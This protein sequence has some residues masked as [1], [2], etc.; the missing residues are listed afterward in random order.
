MTGC[1][2]EDPLGDIANDGFE[3][4]AD[5]TVA[6]GSPGGI[7]WTDNHYTR[8][9]TALARRG[10]RSLRFTYPAQPNPPPSDTVIEQ[11]FAFNQ[12]LTDFWFKYDIFIPANYFHRSTA[13]SNDFGGGEKELVMMSEGYSAPSPTEIYPTMILG[14]LFRRVDQDDPNW[15]NDGSSWQYGSFAYAAA[16]GER[17]WYYLPSAGIETGPRFVDINV[18]PGTW[19]RRIL[20]VRMPTTTNS[21]DG[22]I[23]YWATRCDGT[24]IKVVDEHNGTFHGALHPNSAGGNYITAGYLLGSSNSGFDEETTFYIDDVVVSSTNLWGVE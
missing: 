8:V 24:T 10:T 11:R 5:D 17:T 6:M 14:R 7:E 13:G 15:V 22:E 2:M 23:E 1:S 12:H 18:D 9:S 4:F 3:S 16:D 19:V 20:H 21:N